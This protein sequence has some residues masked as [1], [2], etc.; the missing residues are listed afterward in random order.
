MDKLQM[1]VTLV[2]ADLLTYLRQFPSARER[3]FILRMLAR[4]GL[5]AMGASVA[6]GQPYPLIPGLGVK[7]PPVQIEGA[8]V[9]SQPAFGVTA[10]SSP[11]ASSGPPV[12]AQPMQRPTESSG[13]DG[14]PVDPLAG[15]DIAALNHALARY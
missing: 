14:P 3:S 15:I 8:W 10:V 9:P 5:Q 7:L 6:A 11:A 1:T 2:E 12:A 4:Q 13:G